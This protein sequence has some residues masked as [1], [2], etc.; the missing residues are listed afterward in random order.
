MRIALT[1]FGLY[2]ASERVIPHPCHFEEARNGWAALPLQYK[3]GLAFKLFGIWERWDACWYARIATFGYTPDGA[4]AFFPLF[5]VLERVVALAGPHVAVAGMIVNAVATVLG[6]WGLYR[7]VA[8][9]RG[10]VTARRTM[11]LLAIFPAAVFLLAPFSE[12]IYLA[13]AV[14]TIERARR[15]EWIATA[16]LATLAGIA[17]PVGGFIALPLGWLAWNEIRTPGAQTEAPERRGR[18]PGPERGVSPSEGRSGLWPLIAVLAAPI[19][20]LA[21][22]VYT[23]RVIGRS[24][25]DASAE[26][27]GSAFHPPW[28]VVGATLDWIRRTG[29]PLQALQLALLVLFAAVFV[30]GIRRLPVELTLYAVPHVY[31]VWTRILPTPLTSTARYML[32]IFPAFIVLAMLLEDR[33]AR[34]S[35]A[36]LSLLLLGAL[37]NELVIGNFIG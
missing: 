27:T 34:W 2:V 7:I 6:L 23:V 10:D 13:L 30:V 3:D 14:W 12:A 4:T 25:F 15:G 22:V 26:W 5:P 9:D 19:S 17:R 33:R 37:A 29:D 28:D 8:R 36:I 24:M 1:L 16:V 18:A 35:Y 32:V 11:L 20:A 31:L 21:Y